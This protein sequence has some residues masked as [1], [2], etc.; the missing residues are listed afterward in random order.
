M[1]RTK[2][3]VKMHEPTR[4]AL[5]EIPHTYYTFDFELSFGDHIF[6]NFL[7]L[8]SSIYQ[9]HPQKFVRP[10]NFSDSTTNLGNEKHLGWGPTICALAMP[11]Y[12]S[13]AQGQEQLTGLE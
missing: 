11:P 5:L 2:A 6:K 8:P 1:F 12:I 9:Q 4:A 7:M 3:T 10:L 13:Q